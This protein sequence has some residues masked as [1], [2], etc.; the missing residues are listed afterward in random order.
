METR[1]DRQPALLLLGPTGSGKSPLGDRLEAAGLRG[2]PCLH[3][4]FGSHLRRGAADEGTEG[5]LA[6]DERGVLKRVLAEGALLEDRHFPIA[7]KLFLDFLARRGAGPGTLVVL[8]GLPRHAG[9]AE[10]MESLVAVEAVV[11]LACDPEIVRERIRIDAG[12]DRSGRADDGIEAVRARIETYARRTAPLL[13]R[14]RA[15]GIRVI[16]LAVGA[17]TT[18]E[19]MRRDLE[20]ALARG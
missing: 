6:P 19:A 1:R 13:D 11:H 16:P 7:R 10:A 2:R 4:D 3:F 18:A 12:G 8:N 9:Q 17:R 15:R 14:Y 20:T 5:L